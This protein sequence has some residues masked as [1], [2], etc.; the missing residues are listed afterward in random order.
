M[1]KQ[2]AELKA[3]VERQK[4]EK[5][6]AERKLREEKED[7]IRRRQEALNLNNEKLNEKKQKIEKDFARD[8]VEL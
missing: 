2:M 1:E 7:N 3:E 6:E 5:E 8:E 4:L